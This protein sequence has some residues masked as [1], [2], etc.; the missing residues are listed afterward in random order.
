MARNTEVLLFHYLVASDLWSLP[1]TVEG[2]LDGWHREVFGHTGD[3][4][5]STSCL[6]WTLGRK[7]VEKLLRG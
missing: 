3:M 2:L 4:H 5:S 6:L 7:G 1:M